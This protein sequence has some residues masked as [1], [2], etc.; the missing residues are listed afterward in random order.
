MLKPEVFKAYDIRGVYGVDWDAAGAALVTR[1]FIEKF[2]IKQ[3][4][5]GWDMRVS[6][7]EMVGAIEV[8]AVAAGAHVVKVG[9]VTTPMLYFA[10]AGYSGNGGGI[11]VT[12]SHNT[13]EWNGMKL[14]LGD[15]MP[16]GETSGLPDVKSRALAGEFV[17]A[18]A[19]GSAESRDVLADYLRKVLSMVSLSAGTP[20][21][22]VI[23]CGNGMAGAS[24]RQLLERLPLI[25]AHLMYETPDGTFPHHE[26]NPLKEST[27][28]TLKQE[29]VARGAACGIA[30]DGDGDRIG[31][32]DERG[33]LVSGDALTGLV[34]SELLQH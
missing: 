11:M 13:G 29:V 25:T 7:P 22:V 8:A 15:G 12:A 18:A 32:V 16:V 19:D 20:L 17:D 30:F 5:L 6:S 23:D 2:S 24:I 26:A 9:Q 27:I 14:L 31:F 1:A 33:A 28:T 21:S 3:L 34:G 4:V 10:T